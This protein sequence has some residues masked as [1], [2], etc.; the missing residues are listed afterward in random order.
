VIAL[1]RKQ[2]FFE[3]YVLDIQTSSWSRIEFDKLG[4]K[5]VTHEYDEITGDLISWEILHRDVRGDPIGNPV[6]KG[7]SEDNNDYIEAM[8]ALAESEGLYINNI[9][10]IAETY[11]IEVVPASV[12]SKVDP[13]G[14][15]D[16]ARDSST[17]PD[18]LAK[19]AKHEKWQV[20]AAVADNPSTPE[21]VLK[22]LAEDKEIFV[23]AITANNPNT[24]Q[25]MIL[26][27]V[28][29]NDFDIRAA[30][31]SNP[32]APDSCTRTLSN[33][34]DWR[35]RAGVAKNPNTAPD[36]LKKMVFD[37][38]VDVRWALASNPYTPEDALTILSEDRD[39]NVALSAKTHSSYQPGLA[40]RCEQA[41]EATRGEV[42]ETPASAHEQDR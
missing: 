32:A 21:D 36:V 3:K 17:P 38:S 20:R 14:A 19:L 35:V 1:H 8:I 42:K 22:D 41:A 11:G 37:L 12:I 24:P 40:A 31:A 9:E 13:R 30:V 18:V 33:D 16:I 25:D 4:L 10:A 2:E 34:R 15:D 27:F 7:E 6:I 28:D 5:T 29:S 23:Q 39:V 26:R